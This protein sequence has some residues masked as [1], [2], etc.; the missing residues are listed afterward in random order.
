MTV[1]AERFWRTYLQSQAPPGPA[2]SVLRVRLG[3]SQL[4]FYI[5]V[6][7]HARFSSLLN[8]H[9]N[10]T[11]S[12]SGSSDW[13]S[14]LATPDIGVFYDIVGPDIVVFYRDDIMLKTRI[15]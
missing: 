5:S 2:S 3:G 1:T 6:L 12:D 8:F 10:P 9:L 4:L 7:P 14:G 11:A 13:N 15:S